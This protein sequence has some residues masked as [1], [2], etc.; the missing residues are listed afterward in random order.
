MKKIITILSLWW[1]LIT[2]VNCSP[3]VEDYLEKAANALKQEE[4][5][6]AFKYF[7]MAY[8][9]SLDDSF[10]VF[11]EDDTFSDFILSENKKVLLAIEKQEKNRYESQI[12]KYDLREED[13]EIKRINGKIYNA[14]ISP[15]GSYVI[16]LLQRKKNTLKNCSLIALIN[17]NFIDAKVNLSCN[18]H[19]A[20]SNEKKALFYY[21]NRIASYNFNENI[22][23]KNRFNKKY[24]EKT[25][26]RPLKNLKSFG[27]F[28]YSIKNTPYLTYGSAGIYKLYSL[29]KKRLYLMNKLGSSS[30]IFFKPNSDIPGII[31]G[32]A[33]QRR[34]TFIARKIKKEIHSINAKKY[35]D[36]AFVNKKDFYYI[37][38]SLLQFSKTTK[39]LP[40]FAK[41]IYTDNKSTVYF[42]SFNGYL[43]KY[44][45]TSTN[46][47]H[48]P[49]KTTIS[50]FDK[51]MNL[52]EGQ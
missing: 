33:G 30:K 42:L 3:S 43:M 22:R 49:S 23:K 15:N 44:N 46:I 1:I 41:K 45:I 11:D 10:F 32:G 39:D 20:I 40:F 17:S 28:Y 35:S 8:H 5:S 4:S 14:N 12:I 48:S 19:I 47:S 50:I 37:N 36:I 38:N 26:D 52:F 2:L 18:K 51:C 9:K 13:K 24:I 25:P 31:I 6:D 34:L 21:E 16:F 27:H 29:Y 7:F